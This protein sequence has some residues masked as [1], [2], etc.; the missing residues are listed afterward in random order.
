MD[1]AL[2]Y[3]MQDYYLLA[4]N[5]ADQKSTNK[6]LYHK[7]QIGD[8]KSLSKNIFKN[9]SGSRYNSTGKIYKTIDIEGNLYIVSMNILEFILLPLLMSWIY[10][11]ADAHISKFRLNTRLNLITSLSSDT[12]TLKGFLDAYM[13]YTFHDE[14]SL[15]VY[16]PET[17][18]FTF[19][20]GSERP[21]K[22]Y[23]FFNEN[24]KLNSVL[25]EGY[26]SEERPPNGNDLVMFKKKSVKNLTRL[27]LTLGPHKQ[28]GVLTF[29]SSHEN[30]CIQKSV[31]NDIRSIIEMKYN[32]KLQ[33]SA[34]ALE[35]VTKAL[36]EKRFLK[37]SDYMHVLT[38]KLCELLEYEA[39]S[40][41]LVDNETGDMRLISTFDQDQKG[42]PRAEV[43]YPKG[44]KSLTNNV[45]NNPKYIH[46]I[47]D[48]NDLK[49]NSHIYDEK[50]ENEPKNW[51]GIPICLD[52]N[53]IAVVRVK[54]KYC[55]NRQGNKEIILP[56]PSDHFNL[57][58]LNSIV[59]TH[60]ANIIKMNELNN[61]L[62]MNDQIT[63]NLN[64][65]LDMH[66]NLSKVYR[67]EIRGPVSSIVTIPHQL[68]D[69]LTKDK[70]GKQDIDNVKRGLEDLEALAK[71]LAFIA[72]IQ[73][74]EKVISE[75]DTDGKKMSLLADIVIP[76]DKL[77]KNYYKTKY[78]SKL[79][80]DHTYM[81][82][83]RV[84][85]KIEL[86]NMVLYALLDNAGKYQY[87]E[88][89]EIA[90]RAGSKVDKDFVYLFVE[91][92]GLEI[93]EDE[94]NTIFENDGR[95]SKAKELQIDGSGI[96]LWLCSKI[97]QKYGGNIEIDSRFNPVRFKVTFRKG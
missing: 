84:Y 76:I 83:V 31:I 34:K 61:K 21:E 56:R 37:I 22:E 46:L 27:S 50:T 63:H 16:N 82:G 91:N 17:E 25:A 57:I 7:D 18:C 39:A 60:I 67:H 48:F 9:I 54:N 95:G 30:F 58:T 49:T 68:S 69:M 1:F 64:D 97:M 94:V 77:T 6:T 66:D 42:E 5:S 3:K 72:S 2:L 62:A 23:I 4:K 93:M 78:D 36:Y 81:R 73:N 26:H 11:K 28:R 19:V 12:S 38:E 87:K 92:H 15:W 14:Y 79:Y 40:A 80:F 90:V 10:T 71:N 53:V 44:V 88:S 33:G 96:G 52:D 13:N 85:G 51:L 32:D 55:I 89:G 86:Y 24:S 45:R 8:L 59:E 70:V 47:Y 41:F 20:V 75:E 29:Y 65:R 43:I 74:I 35:D